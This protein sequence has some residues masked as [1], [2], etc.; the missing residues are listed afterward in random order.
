MRTQSG[1]IHL[2]FIRRSRFDHPGDVS[3]VEYGVFLYYH[4]LF[5]MPVGTLQLLYTDRPRVLEIKYCERGWTTS[6]FTPSRA[7]GQIAY[8]ILLQVRSRVGSYH[9]FFFFL[10]IQV[11]DIILTRHVFSSGRPSMGLAPNPKHNLKVALAAHICLIYD[12]TPALDQKDH[13]LRRQQFF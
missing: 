10:R 2:Y 4:K 5:F 13:S 12:I 9:F 7:H 3:V 8:H 1:R 6:L 11:L